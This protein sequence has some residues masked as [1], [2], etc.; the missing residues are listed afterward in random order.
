MT[1]TQSA[2]IILIDPNTPPYEKSMPNVYIKKQEQTKEQSVTARHV[3]ALP[4]H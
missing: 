4:S 2:V 1:D 3:Y